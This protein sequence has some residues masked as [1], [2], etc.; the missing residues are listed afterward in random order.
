MMYDAEIGLMDIDA[1]PRLE[2]ER[3]ARSAHDSDSHG[4]DLAG[5]ES[6]DSG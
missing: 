3:T 4:L 1:R 6:R 5:A 2:C